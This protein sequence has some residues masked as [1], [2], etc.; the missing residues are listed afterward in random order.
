V[1][2]GALRGQYGSRIETDELEARVGGATD[3]AVAVIDNVV[4]LAV[5]DPT[6]KLMTF[7]RVFLFS[8]VIDN[9]VKLAVRS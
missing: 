3:G 4:K 5:D 8:A 9:V 7:G 2:S 6:K 1:V